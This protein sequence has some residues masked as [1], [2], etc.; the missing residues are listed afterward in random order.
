MF[1][2][3]KISKHQKHN[4]EQENMQEIYVSVYYLSIDNSD[5]PTRLN[6][7]VSLAN[8]INLLGYVHKSMEAVTWS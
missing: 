3:P 5:L 1:D 6:I 4:R 7:S 2:T 8:I